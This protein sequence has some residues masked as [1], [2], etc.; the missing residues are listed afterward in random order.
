[1]DKKEKN[2]QQPPKSTSKIA[3]Y[4]VIMLL[5]VI[6]VIIIAAIAD[7]REQ[8]I[9]DSYKSQLDNSTQMNLNIQSQ[10]TSLSN[11]NYELKNNLKSA[12]DKALLYEDVNEVCTTLSEVNNLINDNK[13]EDAQ[14]KF[15]S[16]DKENLPEAVVSYYNMTADKLKAK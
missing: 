4:A 15:D 2:T 3:T 14:A 6:L 8:H 16:I 13:K 1:M 11:E 9:E 12:E 7:N 5:M 10:I